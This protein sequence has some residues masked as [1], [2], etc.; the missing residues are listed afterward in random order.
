VIRTRTMIEI[1]M[2]R[3]IVAMQKAKL[4]T[5]VIIVTE[6]TETKTTRDTRRSKAKK[7]QT[8]SHTNAFKP[9]HRI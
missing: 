6:M 2:A 4:A 3:R 9:Y 8:Y 7:I 1:R 5:K